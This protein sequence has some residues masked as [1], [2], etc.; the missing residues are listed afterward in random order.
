MHLPPVS[1]VAAVEVIVEK[2]KDAI[3]SGNS[4]YSITQSKILN[5]GVHLR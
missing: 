2:G 3:G 1:L 5:P 4:C